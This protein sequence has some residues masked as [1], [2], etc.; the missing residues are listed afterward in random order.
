M[1]TVEGN[2]AEASYWL[3]LESFRQDL[4]GDEIHFYQRSKTTSEALWA[5]SSRRQFLLQMKAKYAR[6][7]HSS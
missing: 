1:I 5:A 7:L 4:F 6:N 2:G 3:T